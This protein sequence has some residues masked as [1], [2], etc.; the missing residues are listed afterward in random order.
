MLIVSC[1]SNTSSK[2]IYAPP[3]SILSVTPSTVT[4]T[5]SAGTV[6]VE[7]AVSLVD[8]DG[9]PLHG[10]SL[11]ISGSFAYPF[12]PTQYQ[13][14]DKNTNAPLSSPFTAKIDDY[15]V[16]KFYILIPFSSSFTESVEITSGSATP[17]SISISFN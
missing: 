5:A 1:G 8:A 2:A 17:T 3:G 14:F 4:L 10:K 12:I 6:R 11:D 15:G 9:N 7:C 16:Y 13:F